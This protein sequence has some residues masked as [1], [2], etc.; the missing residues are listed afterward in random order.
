M[1]FSTNRAVAQPGFI[2]LS[3]D[4]FNRSITVHNPTYPDNIPV[5]AYDQLMYLPFKRLID[6][7]S[8]LIA[9]IV[10]L[11]IFLVVALAILLDSPGPIFYK[12]ERA[13]LNGQSFFMYKF[14]SMVVNA[15]ALKNSLQDLNESNGPF[16]KIKNDPRITR[17]GR[18]IRKYSID[19]L[20]QLLNVLLGDMSLVGPR[21][22]LF[23]EIMQY[24]QSQLQNLCIPPGLTCYWQISGRSDSDVERI[25][26]DT[27]Y[28]QELNLITDCKILLK[29]PMA[30][31]KGRGAC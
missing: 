18:F 23:N 26:L 5:L 28:I 9:L 22:A 21:P 12:Q 13:G 17:V 31:I 30:V 7:V 8:S 20:P 15:D 24:T 3:H 4:I 19:E 14:R 16:F 10:F 25:N 1:L 29:T 27:K 6:I 2:D 11:P